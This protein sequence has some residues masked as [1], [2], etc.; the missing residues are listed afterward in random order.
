MPQFTTSFGPLTST[1]HGLVVSTILIPA[2]VSSFFGGHVAN[3][4]GRL[5][6][7]AVGASIF[8]LGAAIEGGSVKLG[9]LIAGR[10]IKGIGEGLFLSTLVVYITELSP[11]RQRGMLASIPQLLTTIGV[12]SG[13]FICYGSVGIDSSLSWRTP[14][15]I[16]ACIAFIFAFST[17]F[18]LPES[19]R[20]LTAVGRH[21]EA[22]KVWETLGIEE[23]E[24]EKIS[25]QEDGAALPK[26]VE[27]KDILSVFSADAWRQTALGV[28]LMG[29][30]QASGIDGVLYYAPL[31]FASAGLSSSTASFLASGISA[32]LIFLITIPGT[33]YADRWGRTTSTI[34]G[35]L[36][37]AATMF[38]MGALYASNSVHASS[39]VGR[40]VVIAMIYLF[41]MAFSATWG[42]SFRVY[43]SEIQSAK[44][45][46]GAASLSLSAN[47]IV[48]WI[49]AFTTPILLSKSSYG[50]YFL[51]GGCTL[52]TSVVCM[53][54]MPETRGRSLEE[55][56]ESF[57]DRRKR[58][59]AFELDSEVGGERAGV[60]V[61]EDSEERKEAKENV[62]EVGG[63]SGSSI[64]VS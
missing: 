31:L 33:F 42:V 13:F 18:F 55:I 50:V 34:Y 21:A 51:F 44:T 15:I 12:C 58:G 8:G 3:S 46:A 20:W 29:M 43:I 11:P 38:V 25:D 60:F 57:G 56:Q 6:G 40:Y 62:R 36:I 24:R 26:S 45:R 2:A 63:S 53:F 4:V 35:G 5:K 17:F 1:V 48:N 30:Q 10:A 32:L 22:K 64:V 27:M 39:G 19:P 61:F 49:I 47:W 41:A 14:Y 9:M 54:A 23:R 59:T 37:Q 28:F 7:V 52:F 16:Q